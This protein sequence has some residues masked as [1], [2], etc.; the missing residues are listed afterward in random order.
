LVQNLLVK[1]SVVVLAHLVYIQ[2]LGKTRL[3][4][5]VDSFYRIPNS[6]AD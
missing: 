5:L 6:Q 2:D 3:F 1:A 4:H